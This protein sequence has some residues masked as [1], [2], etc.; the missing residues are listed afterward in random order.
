LLEY[1]YEKHP[2]LKQVTFRMAVNKELVTEN[3]NLD[4]ECTVA[5]L[6]AFSGG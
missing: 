4:K 2:G 5:L 1:L 6:P 3:T